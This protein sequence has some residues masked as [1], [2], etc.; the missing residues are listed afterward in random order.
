MKNGILSR[1][2]SSIIV[3]YLSIY[4]NIIFLHYYIFIRINTLSHILHRATLIRLPC[5]R[6]T[7]TS[8]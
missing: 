6:A 2:L 3:V 7:L 8:T 4:K 5:L 1:H